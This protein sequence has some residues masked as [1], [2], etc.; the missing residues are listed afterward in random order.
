ML[1]A[2][3]TDRLA[4]ASGPS[5]PRKRLSIPTAEDGSRALVKLSDLAL[6]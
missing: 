5:G 4:V 1:P 3:L 2:L 6:Q